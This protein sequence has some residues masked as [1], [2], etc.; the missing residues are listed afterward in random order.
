MGRKFKKNIEP[1]YLF[2]FGIIG[3]ILS[4]FIS[5]LIIEFNNTISYYIGLS[6]PIISVIVFILGCV[7]METDTKREKE[8]CRLNMNEFQN[9][10]NEY[11]KKIGIVQDSMYV[12]LFDEEEN[13]FSVPQYL[14]IENDCLNLFPMSKYYI[15]MH[16]SSM[17]KPD[18]SKLHIKSIPI[19]NI[20]YFEEIGELRKYTTV[21]GGGSSLKGALVGY[22]LADDIGAIIGSRKPIETRVVS[23]DDRKIELIYKNDKGEISNLEFAHNAYEVLKEIIPSKELR[24]IA[25]LNISSNIANGIDTPKSITVKEKLKQLNDLKT[26][27]LI[28]DVEFSEQKQKILDSL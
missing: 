23:E 18:I 25:G 9:E 10:Y 26:E 20:L 6:I 21:S 15:Q 12:T 8:K 24:R 28:T 1:V 16:T 27:G 7:G 17:H 3:V 19:D 4:I 2:I 5:P 13:Y 22:V 11:I 14:W